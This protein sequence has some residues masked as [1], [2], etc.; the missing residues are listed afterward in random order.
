LPYPPFEYQKFYHTNSP[1]VVGFSILILFSAFTKVVGFFMLMWPVFQL[2]KTA[3]KA[4]I[5][6]GV[7]KEP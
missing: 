1:G 5:V 7:A 2:T 4:R 6:T 3:L